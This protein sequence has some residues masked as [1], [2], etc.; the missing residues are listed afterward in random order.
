MNADG[1]DVTKLVD[2]DTTK[3][4]LTYSLSPDCKKVALVLRKNWDPDSNY[5]IAIFDIDTRTLMNNME[6]LT[7]YHL[8]ELYIDWR[9]PDYSQ[10]GVS[11]LF[12]FTTT[13]GRIK[14]QP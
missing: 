11:P 4:Y 14:T 6:R 9:D 8:S 2:N 7:N 1:N 3:C 5:D 13:W 10:I 12:K